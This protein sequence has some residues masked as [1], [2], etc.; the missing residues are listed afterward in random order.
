MLREGQILA[1]VREVMMALSLTLAGTGDALVTN[2]LH[3][4][5]G[6]GCCVCGHR[7]PFR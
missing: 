5:A 7:P 1:Y 4:F 2:T 6:S 3:D